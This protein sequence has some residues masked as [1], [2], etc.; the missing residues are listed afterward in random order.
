[1][2]G[3]LISEN[4]IGRLKRL[5]DAFE[6]GRFNQTKQPLRTPVNSPLETYLAKTAEEITKLSTADVAG[7]GSCL[8]CSLT[9]SGAISAS[10]LT[11]TVW[12]ISKNNLADASYVYLTRD[13]IGGKWLAHALP[14]SSSDYT[15][16]EVVTGSSWSST[17][18]EL[19]VTTATI[20]H[21]KG[22]TS[23]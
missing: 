12:N 7:S 15:E 17:G 16:T 21:L 13:P 4:D 3:Y 19:T 5:L 22:S 14:A 18:C 6:S 23:T 2:T 9:S 1:M 20:R 10:T 11:V 8:L